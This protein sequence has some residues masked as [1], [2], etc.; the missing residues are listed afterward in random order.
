MKRHP[1]AVAV[2]IGTLLTV[3]ACS[4]DSNPIAQEPIPEPTT[5]MSIRA[6]DGYL[7]NAFVWLDL[8]RDY[9]FDD[10]VEPSTR[11]ENGLAT[12]DVSS[13]DD[14]E[15]Y[16]V[17]VK[18]IQ[19]ETIDLDN[20]DTTVAKN[21]VMSAPSGSAVVSPL[22]TMVDFKMR[23]EG[24][25]EEAAKSDIAQMFGI[26]PDLIDSDYQDA[27]TT[28]ATVAVKLVQQSAK[29]IV[30]AGVLPESETELDENTL[31]GMVEQAMEE[32]SQVGQ[33]LID[34]RGENIAEDYDFDRVVSEEK[35]VEA[36]TDK[37]GV[38][39]S[40]DDFPENA[41]EWRDVDGDGHGDNLADK[42]PTNKDEWEDSDGDGYGD[43]LAD[44]FPDDKT[45]WADFD[46]DDIGDNSDPDD[47]NDDVNDEDDAFPYDETE[48][49]DTDGDTIG[50][51]ADTDDDGDKVDDIDDK[52]PLDASEWADSDSDSV[53][54]NSDQYPNDPDKS[55]ADVVIQYAYRSPMFVDILMDVKTLDVAQ[56]ITIETLND[57]SIRRTENTVY[58]VP[59]TEVIFGEWES[60][61]LYKDDG[62]FER[63]SFGY[64]D[65]NL[66]G[67]IQYESQWLD[68]GT[69]TQGHERFWRYI[70][71][72]DAALEGG[73]NG[74]GREF[75]EID[76]A[77]QIANEDLSGVDAIQYLT[78]D[79]R[80]EDAVTT[81]TTRIKQYVIDGWTFGD[82]EGELNYSAQATASIA[83]GVVVDYY[84]TRDWQADGIVNTA[85]GFAKQNDQQYTFSYFRPVW[86]APEQPYFEEYA[87]YSYIK[88]K[89]DVLGNYWYEVTTEY[90]EQAKTRSVTGQRFILSNTDSKLV[91]EAYPQGVLFNGYQ[92]VRT[93]R[94][95]S[96][97]TEAVNW[98][99]LPISD[100]YFASPEGNF[101]VK[102][103]DVGQDYKVFTKH[104]NGLWVGQRF[105]EWGSQLV[106]DLGQEIES[107]RSSGYALDEID[108]SLLPGLSDYNGMLLGESFQYD[109]SGEARQWYVVT[110]NDLFTPLQDG[111]YQLVPLQL[112]HNGIKPN[113]R[114]ND[115]Q[116]GTIVISVPHTDNPW[117]WYDAYWRL[118]LNADE[119][120]PLTGA[121]KNWLGEF[122]LSEEEAQAAIIQHGRM[123][124]LGNTEWDG[125]IP[126]GEP[127][128]TDYAALLEACYY[129]QVTEQEIVGQ[130]Y[131]LFNGQELQQWHF[132]D[133]G[134]GETVF[135][136]GSS[137]SF[138]WSVNNDGVIKVDYEWGPV[139]YFAF[140]GRDEQHIGVKVYSQWNDFGEDRFNIWAARVTTYPPMITSCPLDQDNASYD[141]FYQAIAACGGYNP[142][143]GDFENTLAGETFVR[144]RSDGDT[145]AYQFHENGQYNLIRA[146]DWRSQE[147]TLWEVTPEGF[148][149][150]MPDVNT[151]DEFM[152][153]AHQQFYDDQSSF[154]VYEQYTD[155]AQNHSDIW[156]FVF[157]EYEQN[158]PLSVCNTG[159]TPW[160]DELD[161]PPGYADVQ[162][163]Q[164][165]V[166]QCQVLTDNR[167]LK[168]TEDMLVGKEGDQQTTWRITTDGD[169]ENIRFNPNR[170]G[171]FVDPEDG[172]FP[173]D[174]QLV[175]G[176]VHL[177]ITH[178]D[179]IG[180]SEIISITESDGIQFVLKSF[181]IDTSGEWANPAPEEGEGEIWGYI[182]ELVDKQ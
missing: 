165:S 133:Q 115:S 3:A 105:A 41:L 73:S 96:E 151:Q 93:D 6:I 92:A 24:I 120:E 156:S 49:I 74:T 170:T 14:P 113:W 35:A 57:A 88:D 135:A 38:A 111:E 137:A 160:N 178:P 8:D 54:D 136:D 154:V 112:T 142:I 10:S 106:T 48:W 71:E 78:I 130:S 138:D 118:M 59:D 68:I 157:R 75:D 64:Y 33:V 153:L 66:D 140:T 143:E 123:C 114:V 23:Q 26:E 121:W 86:A 20:P 30:T 91:D 177:T 2:G 36:D 134:K 107:L 180:S 15:S 19:K 101:T 139:D 72:S 42:F 17:V 149:K 94:S 182:I 81:T 155:G 163:Y 174:W 104:E 34:D 67:Y 125:G 131:Y 69:Y 79:S 25:S 47:D 85:I 82:S 7:H 99:H 80:S 32:G 166:Q 147:G 126:I 148:L 60:H 83:D 50:N 171:A 65:Y 9:Q 152:L 4:D 172:E 55:V 37:D 108:A 161:Q 100:G 103:I 164:A 158:Q 22:T 175:D 29:S 176:Q 110:N 128:Y 31:G 45:E 11:S 28:G 51:N 124:N 62:T 5:S 40:E 13:I 127:Q 56:D 84:D 162:A 169:G 89:A 90:D 119:V 102:E 44:Q 61:A 145:R 167:A 58:T 181:W 141:D 98:S 70:D 159:N 52:F 168:F 95:E 18:A 173:F 53:G 150:I 46:K 1:I 179:Y 63:S 16:P 116:S 132:Y 146:G 87:Q 77:S 43:N 144:V 21:F 129:L 109:E 12:L 97:Y 117:N 39:D 76:I 122:Y 27:A